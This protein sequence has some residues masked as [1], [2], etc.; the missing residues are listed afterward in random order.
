MFTHV[1]YSDNVVRCVLR[2][3]AAVI[4]SDNTVWN[5]T[6]KTGRVCWPPPEINLYIGLCGQNSCRDVGAMGACLTLEREEGRAKKR[7]EEI[8]RQL[9]EFAKLQNN[10]IKILLLGKCSGVFFRIASVGFGDFLK[11][12]HLIQLNYLLFM[13]IL[14]RQEFSFIIIYIGQKCDI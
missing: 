5:G 4:H 9:G 11:L 3:I 6:G 2:K 10:V 7:S 8:D 12:T 14:V 13:S 1:P